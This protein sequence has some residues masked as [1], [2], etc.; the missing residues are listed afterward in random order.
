MTN[1]RRAGF[2]L[3][4]MLVVTVL[5][6]I[7]VGSALQILITN[8]RTYTAQAAKIESQRSSR[9]ALDV[10][11]NELREVSSRDG[12]IL[13]MDTDSIQIRS[14]RA[15]GV[16]CS[17]SS[18]SPPVLTVIKVGNWFSAG[19]S[20]TVFADNQTETAADD[21]WFKA[22]ITSVDTTATCNGFQSQR[23]SFSGQAA[24]FTAD[25]VRQGAS[26]R[27]FATYT[28]GSFLFRSEVYLGRGDSSGVMVPIIGPLRDSG[29]LEFAYLDSLGAATTTATNVRLI[30]V[31]LRTGGDGIANT[32]GQ[33]VAD[34]VTAT[35]YTRN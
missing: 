28:Y 26:V 23:L 7:V 11:T 14:M 27:G 3:I 2:T 35:I 6:A 8:Q 21:N 12:D 4:E 33:E 25:S 17:V 22:R 32:V 18:A 20:V 5:G 10:L 29:G 13:D 19:D 34:S 24:L 1:V 16:T 9:A 30:Q 31:T 15:F